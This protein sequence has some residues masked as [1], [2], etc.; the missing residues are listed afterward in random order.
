MSN[1]FSNPVTAPQSMTIY[2]VLNDLCKIFNIARRKISTTCFLRQA[3]KTKRLGTIDIVLCSH[4]K[5]NTFWFRLLN[6]V[7]RSVSKSLWRMYVRIDI[8]EIPVYFLCCLKPGLTR[9]KHRLLIN[10]RFNSTYLSINYYINVGFQ[11]FHIWPHEEYI[12]KCEH[13]DEFPYLFHKFRF[14][15]ISNFN[16]LCL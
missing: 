14:K 13:K 3:A 4:K 10:S 16:T 9:E 5:K 7:Y 15:C 12:F 2:Y 11:M 8:P 6:V 1:R